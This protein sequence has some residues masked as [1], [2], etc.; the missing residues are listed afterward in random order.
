MPATH[1]ASKAR[2]LDA[3]VRL[4]R[5]KGYGAMTVDDVCQAAKLTKG[6]FFHHFKSK[7]ELG[8]AAAAHFSGFAD[9]IFAQATYR[10]LADPLARLLGYIDFRIA[11]L[12][13]TLPEFTC[14]L[15]TMVQ[16]TYETHPALREA[17]NT[18]ICA[19]AADVSADISMAKTLYVPGAD[20]TPDGLAFHLQAVIQGAFILAK[21]KNGPEIATEC[22]LH[23]RRYLELLF[24]QRE[25]S[26]P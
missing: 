5:T 2:I 10:T 21:A 14:L 9:Q 13:G 7:E 12:H 24:G 20:W 3:A 16:E 1:H 15:G 8:L 11:I 25:A 22:L 17:C 18:Y 4:V 26:N 23:L 19:H 6:S